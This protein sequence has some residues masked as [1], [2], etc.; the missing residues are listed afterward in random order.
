MREIRPLRAKYPNSPY[1]QSFLVIYETVVSVHSS[2]TT[3]T[4]PIF[5]ILSG[6]RSVLMSD[7]QF[8]NFKKSKFSQ[9]VV[10]VGK[11]GFIFLNFL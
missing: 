8:L 3:I 1:Q 5:H 11:D 7:S 9:Q 10:L 6:I 2:R 4:E